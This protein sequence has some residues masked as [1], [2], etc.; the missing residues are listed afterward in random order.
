[1]DVSD[2]YAEYA[3]VASLDADLAGVDVRVSGGRVL[4][5]G[6]VLAN[7]AIDQDRSYWEVKIEALPPPVGD[8]EEDPF[9]AAVTGKSGQGGLCRIGVCENLSSQELAGHVPSVDDGSSGEGRKGFVVESCVLYAP[10]L[11]QLKR[12]DVVGVAV[13]L[14]DFPMISFYLNGS[15]LS[16]CDV[17]RFQGTV[18]PAVSV[19]NGAVLTVHFPS[20]AWVHRPPTASFQPLLRS[21]DM[22]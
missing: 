3:H 22:I 13:Q 7:Q 11:E 21:Q 12:G 19:S 20:S 17:Q 16:G 4:G 9:A 18:F 15:R 10:T 1:M 5:H 6:T 14:S 2:T 8:V